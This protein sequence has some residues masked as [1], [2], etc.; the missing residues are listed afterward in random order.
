E[1]SDLRTPA[2]HDL[3]TD[4]AAHREA[5]EADGRLE[6]IEDG[7][8]KIGVTAQRSGSVH[9]VAC[10]SRQIW[11]E[12]PKPGGQLS[13]NRRPHG[14]VEGIPVDEKDHRTFS[15]LPDLNGFATKIEDHDA[16]IS[17]GGSTTSLELRPFFV[18]KP[19]KSVK[20]LS[21]FQRECL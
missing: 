20:A 1:R 3:Q 15:G 19:P 4:V 10:S 16:M 9:R 13:R 6:L 17:C 7:S 21:L 14:S 18:I 8:D 5:G 12:N 11:F 2:A